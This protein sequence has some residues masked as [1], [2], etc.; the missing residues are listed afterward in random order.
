MKSFLFIM[1]I[2]MMT[3]LT[4]NASELYRYSLKKVDGSSQE[5][6]SFKDKVVLVTNIATRCGYTPQLDG[7]EKL[8]QK[9]KDKGLVILGVPSNNFWGQT[10][11]ENKDV[12]KFCKLKYG[13]TFPVYAKVDVK[14][15]DM[16]ELYKFIKEKRKGEDIGW[17][18]EKALFDRS[19]KFISAYTSSVKPLDSDL[20]GQI[21]KL[22]K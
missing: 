7:L 20:E 17:N 22:L 10:P 13:V 2:T 6:K 1:M 5:L 14:G 16:I 19:G 15:D 21:K 11:E 9:Y 8:Y 4:L 3:S 12:V 18:F